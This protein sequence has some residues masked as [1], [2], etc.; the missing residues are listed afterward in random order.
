MIPAMKKIPKSPR[1]LVL[2]VALT[3]IAA[4]IGFAFLR[5]A[6]APAGSGG[7]SPSRDPIAAVSYSDFR[8]MLAR[9]EIA[10][11]SL[12]GQILTLLT[13]TGSRMATRVPVN[14]ES[15]VADA[16]IQG[17]A[18]FAV[19][20]SNS[21]IVGP[22]VN[23]ATG[24][25]LLVMVVGFVKWSGLNPLAAGRSRAKLFAQG[26]NLV[27]F[28]DVA[29]V[30]DAKA[31][32]GEIVQFLKNPVYFSRLGGQLPKGV[33]L[34]GPPGNGKTLLARAIAGEAGVPFFS[35]AGSAFT[36]MYV[37]VGAARVRDLFKRAKK[38]AP[39]IVFI[40]EVDAVGSARGHA[41]SHGDNDKTLNQLLVEMDGFE[42]AKGVIVIAATNRPELLDSALLRPGRFDRH[43]AVS[44]PDLSGRRAILD[45]HTKR[46]LLADG[47]ELELVA[48]GTPGFSGAELARLANEAA[49]LAA[50]RGLVA[51]DMDCLEAAKDKVLMGSERPSL[52][53]S[54]EERRI[55]AYHEAGHALVALNTPA[56]DPIHKATIMPRGQSLGMVVRLAKG[57]RWSL[58]R[59]KL[60]ADLA[61]AMGG[62]VAEELVMGPAGT[63]TGAAI[64]IK[65]ATRIARQMVVHWGM[66][67]ALGPLAYG[68]LDD[69]VEP[70]DETARLIDSE[71]KRIVEDSKNR[72]RAI[73]ESRR[74]ELDLVA[75]ALLDR[76][77]LTAA[78]IVAVIEHI[79]AGDEHS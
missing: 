44:A 58:T 26:G 47:V 65:Q 73:L 60:E 72:A 57:D 5:N 77:T 63:T 70:A 42:P 33:L 15:S 43:V 34:S 17:G 78:E 39:C 9:S 66:S 10:S 19:E 24:V 48:R 36:E 61:V 49:L 12:S 8:K 18:D 14:S 11:G 32:L 64:D 62:R 13:T 30:D 4:G 16:M 6:S 68:D 69:G 22:I 41:R 55:T 67:D 29:G 2:L 7:T 40:D 46:L 59:A 27:T 28:A 20:T 52:A 35:E 56:S 75:S 53:L 50:G 21:D 25:L 37:G 76:E 54:E 3:I 79:V 71:V 31:E 74:A 1:Y 45:A 51:I 23:I 38:H